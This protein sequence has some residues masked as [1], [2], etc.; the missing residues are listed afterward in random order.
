M[1]LIDVEQEAINI[2]KKLEDNFCPICGQ[3]IDWEDEK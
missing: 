3:A 1:R 2:I